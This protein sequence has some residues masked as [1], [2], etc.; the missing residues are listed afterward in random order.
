MKIVLF[1]TGYIDC[2]MIDLANALSKFEEIVLLLPENVL[3]DRHLEMISNEVVF[4]PFYMPRYHSISSILLMRQIV[5]TIK[6]HDPDIL[7]VQDGGHPWFFLAF[8]FLKRYPIVST[9]HDPRPHIGEERVWKSFV[10]KRGQKHTKRYIVHG[11][12]MKEL[13]IQYYYELDDGDIDVIPLGIADLHRNWNKEK[14]ETEKNTILYFGRIWKYKGLDYLIKAEPIISQNIREY[15]IVIAGI[16]EDVGGYRSLMS[17]S[18]K[19]VWKNYRIDNDK[20]VELFQKAAI[21]VLPYIEG[22]QSAVVPLAYAFGKPVIVTKVGSIFEM[23]NDGK[24]GFIIPPQ[25]EKALAEKIISLLQDD[26]L[27][28]AMGNNANKVGKVELSWEAIAK[29]TIN[30]YNKLLSK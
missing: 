29:M 13:M 11:K 23:V 7:H 5:K 2:V 21:I 17:D 10:M 16:G 6:R 25:D 27:R 8:P 4:E 24:T 1:S 15:K 18:S 14:F 9:I 26:K 30:T 12:R 19:F 3:T 22:T 20:I 28:V